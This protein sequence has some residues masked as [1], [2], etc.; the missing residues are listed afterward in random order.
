LPRPVRCCC[1]SRPAASGSRCRPVP[2]PA[3]A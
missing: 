1:G 3:G 2:D